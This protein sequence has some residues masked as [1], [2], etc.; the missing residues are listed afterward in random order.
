M[1]IIDLLN[2]IANGEKIKKI[3]Y[4]NHIYEYYNG[5]FKEDVGEYDSNWLFASEII[6]LEN[7]ND[8]I[9]IMENDKEDKKIEKLDLKYDD[10]IY[11]EDV[12]FKKEILLY[13]DNLQEKINEIVDKLEELK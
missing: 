10:I 5:D 8:E 4:Q 7:L 13:C 9:E 1:K 12:F 2:K 11:H 6:D 3:K